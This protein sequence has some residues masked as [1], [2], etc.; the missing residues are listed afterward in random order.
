MKIRFLIAASLFAVPV[1]AF[2]DRDTADSCKPM[3]VMMGVHKAEPVMPDEF[4]KAPL[5][6]KAQNESTGPAVLIPNCKNDDMKP[7]K[8]GDYPLA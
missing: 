2:Q 4:P 8:K 5:L 1:C 7:R 3:D 6:S